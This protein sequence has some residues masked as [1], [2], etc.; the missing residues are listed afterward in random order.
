MIQPISA[1]TAPK[2]SR[3]NTSFT[4]TF[5]LNI[6]C[7]SVKAVDTN[8]LAANPKNAINIWECAPEHLSQTLSVTSVP[9]GLKTTLS[10][11][12]IIRCFARSLEPITEKITWRWCSARLMTI[13]RKLMKRMNK[14]Q[15]NQERKWV[16]KTSKI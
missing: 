4:S 10:Y 1:S 15:N 14:H 9:W 7:S 13:Q 3:G 11:W 6:Q 16:F 8:S 12:R 5:L 2:V